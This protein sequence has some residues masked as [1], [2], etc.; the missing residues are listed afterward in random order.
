MKTINER[1]G[2]GGIKMKKNKKIKPGGWGGRWRRGCSGG[3]SSSS[4][5]R[6]RERMRGRE[7]NVDLP[8]AK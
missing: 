1:G 5:E 8:R 4:G 2:R 3:D 6:E 7:K